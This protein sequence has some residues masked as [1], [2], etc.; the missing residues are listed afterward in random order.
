MEVF[1]NIKLTKEEIITKLTDA[2]KGLGI[3]VSGVEKK[4]EKLYHFKFSDVGIIAIYITKDGFM[5]PKYKFGKMHEQGRELLEIAVGDKSNIERVKTTYAKYENL[6]TKFSSNEQFT[7]EFKQYIENELGGTIQLKHATLY[8]VFYWDIIKDNEKV[9]V[10]CYRTN[11]LLQGKN[12]YL[13]DDICIWIE[14]KLDSPVS[15]MLVR[16]TGD[17]NIN[18]KIATTAI[19]EAENILKDRLKTAYDILFPHDRKFL[20]SAI[21]LI[22][23]NNPLQEY[24]AI[25]NPAFKGLEGYLRKMIA[26]KIGSRIPEVMKKVYDPKLSLSWLVEKDKYMDTYFINR[27]YGDSRNPSNDRA[28]EGLYKIYKEDRNPYSHSTGLATRTCD[29]IED[30]KD[31]VDQILSAISSTYSIFSR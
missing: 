16:I 23:Y 3:S 11:L 19:N 31:I 5:N 22:L 6:L 12:N 29:S 14:Q 25:I 1:E 18:G 20:N 28:F 26:E 27:N 30:A 4:N 13:W 2:C 10:H 17:E 21:C 15:E 7:E 8:E 24:S 9:T